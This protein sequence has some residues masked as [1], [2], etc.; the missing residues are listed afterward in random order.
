[1]NGQPKKVL[2]VDDDQSAVAF[3]RGALEPQRFV[4]VGVNNG[5]AG[6]SEAKK[7]RPDVIILD[8]YMPGQTGFYTLQDLKADPETKSIPIIM[9]TGVSKRLGIN[10]STRDLYDTMGAEPDIYLEKPIDP[11]FLRQVTDKLLGVGPAGEDPTGKEGNDD[12]GS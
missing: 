4:V 12:D 3:V 1:M 7:E 8:V 10:F 5:Q 11:M 2:V 6:L 9:L